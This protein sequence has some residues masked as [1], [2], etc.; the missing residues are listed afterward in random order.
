MIMTGFT[1]MPRGLFIAAV[2]LCLA[3]PL[4]ATAQAGGMPAKKKSMGLEYTTAGTHFSEYTSGLGTLN[5]WETFGLF[6]V[7]YDLLWRWKENDAYTLYYGVGA[8]VV[9]GGYDYEVGIYKGSGGSGPGLGIRLLGEIDYPL[10]EGTTLLGQ[11]GVSLLYLFSGSVDD[12]TGIYNAYDESFGTGLPSLFLAAGLQKTLASGR[13]IG[14]LIRFQLVDLGAW[15][16]YWIVNDVPAD[17]GSTMTTF[18]FLYF[19]G[20]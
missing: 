6:G 5:S 3:L 9:M 20:R 13:S 17:E 14:L 1:R 16:D 12:D 15:T 7:N 4:T 11:A 19:L 2:V 8:S 10:Q 18:Q